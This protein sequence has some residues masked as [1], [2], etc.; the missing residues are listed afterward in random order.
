[1]IRRISR[2][3]KRDGR[4][5]KFDETKI[6]DAIHKAGCAVGTDDRFLAEELAGVVNLFLEKSYSGGVPGIEE[7]QDMVEKVLMETGHARMA[8]AYI[9][10][11][12]KRA[13]SR[14]RVS[15]HGDPSSG[16][17]VGNPAKAVVS[18]W[19]KGRIAEALVREADL[20]DRVAAEVAGRV[21]QKVF[22]AHVPRITTAA[23]R[24]LV[25]AELFLM[26]YGDRVGRQ[27]LVGLP[28][29]DVNRLLHG[30]KG[31]AWR[32]SGPRDLKRA[33]ADSI[34]AQYALAEIYSAEVGDAHMDGRIHVLDAG[35]PFEWVAGSVELPAASDPDSWVES[36]A[37]HLGRI[38]GMVTREVTLSG[39]VAGAE[40]WEQSGARPT[41]LLAARRLIGH[42][43]LRMIDRRGGRLRTA[44]CLPLL[45]SDPQER[46]LSDALVREHWA[47]FR[48]GDVE[49]LPTLLLRIPVSIAGSEEARR[50]LLPALAAAAETGRVEFVFDRDEMLPLVTPW[51]RA[52]GL[53]ATPGVAQPVAGAV[54]VD[55][56]GLAGAAD[57]SALLE[58][59]ESVLDLALKAIRQKRNF[60][61]ELQSEPSMPLY[62]VAAG[63]RPVV[64]G[65]QGID[66][67]HLCG[68]RAA[69]RSLSRDGE[70]TAR[71]ARRLRSYAGVRIAEEGRPMRLRA[72]LAPDRDGDGA[73]RFAERHGHSEDAL[74]PDLEPAPECTSLLPPEVA[75]LTEP[76]E[77]AVLLQF[78]REHAPA[79]ETLYDVVVA[80]AADGRTRR[81]RL[82]PW[83]DRAIQRPIRRPAETL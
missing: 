20:D 16:P 79:P 36:A 31:T 23:I 53:E 25:E 7:I 76:I 11:R 49:R 47:S 77:E 39:M 18:A 38:S 56:A 33:V 22:A 64:A 67:I 60:L 52:R 35:C 3:R 82:Q 8:K 83:P 29:F 9:L 24:S 73:R 37:L 27:A 5:V 71:I 69:A 70:E 55:V 75:C 74:T 1:M 59:L 2:V 43:A 4:L 21:E 78:P 26:E 65:G 66:L 13:R 81:L 80:L 19:S 45:A 48:A 61:A 34:L 50:T 44:F 40:H 68:V 46:A 72:L 12:E 51:Y 10:Y 62:R 57:E 63:A 14:E 32:P 28:R 15:V 41:A 58:R 6:A 54:A 17:M 42:A 30:G